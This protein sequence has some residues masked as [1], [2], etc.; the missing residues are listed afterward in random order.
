MSTTA[1]PA[2]SDTP[3]QTPQPVSPLGMNPVDI[4]SQRFG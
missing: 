1:T 4:D 2:V 3:D